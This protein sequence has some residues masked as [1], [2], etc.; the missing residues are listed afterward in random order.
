MISWNEGNPNALGELCRHL[1]HL[2]Q[3]RGTRDGGPAPADGKAPPA[4][5]DGEVPA[6]ADGGAPTSGSVHQAYPD[7]DFPAGTLLNL[8]VVQRVHRSLLSVSSKSP[9]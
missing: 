7:D 2:P 8:A 9:L 5:T 3:V 6:P 1:P 4:L